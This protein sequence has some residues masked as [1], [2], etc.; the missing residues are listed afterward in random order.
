MHSSGRSKRPPATRRPESL[1]SKKIEYSSNPG[2]HE[3]DQFGKFQ[4]RDSL[5]YPRKPVSKEP[6][7]RNSCA[8]EK[9]R[10][11]SS[12]HKW[13]AFAMRSADR[14]HIESA[15]SSRAGM[16]KH[17]RAAQ[18][19]KPGADRARAATAMRSALARSA[20]RSSGAAHVPSS[21][22]PSRSHA[23]IAAADAMR[24]VYVCRR[25]RARVRRSSFSVDLCL[26]STNRRR[27][28]ECVARNCALRQALRA[29]IAGISASRAHRW[30][31]L[32]T[33]RVDRLRKP[34]E[35]TRLSQ[36]R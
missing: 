2:I 1:I 32:A 8:D 7:C 25:R 14:E 9:S 16:N 6:P 4:R 15:H 22:R 5:E 21:L 24:V 36:A 23:A 3:G 33:L 35:S 31:A 34:Q 19:S 18:R 11:V 17:A 28:D 12:D 29:T 20:A 13:S 10:A 26:S 27:N 30:G